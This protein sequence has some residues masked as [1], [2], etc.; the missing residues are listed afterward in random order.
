MLRYHRFSLNLPSLK[1]NLFLVMVAVT[2]S[3]FFSPGKT[4]QKIF[5]VAKRGYAK[6]IHCDTQMCFSILALDKLSHDRNGTFYPHGNP[7]QPHL[8]WNVLSR[9]KPHTFL[10]PHPNGSHQTASPAANSSF[11]RVDS[12]HFT[13]IRS[14]AFLFPPS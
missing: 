10:S 11:Q 5:A 13:A 14:G 9:A 8:N 1:T 6:Q 2:S 12:L 4:G 3:I 7:A